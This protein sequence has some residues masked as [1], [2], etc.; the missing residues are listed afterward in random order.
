MAMSKKDYVLIA[1]ICRTHNW[2]AAPSEV[3]SLVRDLAK[4]FKEENSRFN[5][6]E[7]LTAC[8]SD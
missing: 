8:G 6:D 1:H 3:D 5:E 2:R 7:F 4:A